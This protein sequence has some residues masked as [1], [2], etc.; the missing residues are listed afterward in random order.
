MAYKRSKR[1]NSTLFGSNSAGVARNSLL[2]FSLYSQQRLDL[3]SSASVN[4]KL[5]IA[6]V[7][8]VTEESPLTRV[9]SLGDVVWSTRYNNSRQSC[10]R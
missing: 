9:S 8:F 1:Q 7:I 3:V 6:L 2:R 4:H 10:H 5:E